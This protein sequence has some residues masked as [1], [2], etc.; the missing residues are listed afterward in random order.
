MIIKGGE[1]QMAKIKKEDAALK[2]QLVDIRDV[3]IDRS[4]P[5]E[6]RVK[7]FIEQIKNPYQFKVGDTVVKVS[8]ANTQN[9]IT[10]NFINMIAT[11]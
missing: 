11:M 2:E 7:S 5:M 4:L 1:L 6:E 3:K 10:D 9:T 8:F